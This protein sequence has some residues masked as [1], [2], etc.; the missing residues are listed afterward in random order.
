M[1]LRDTL[2]RLANAPRLIREHNDRLTL[3]GPA[4]PWA[5]WP[6]HL[7]HIDAPEWAQGHYTLTRHHALKVP[8]VARARGLICGT[9]ARLPMQVCNAPGV[10]LAPQ[11]TWLDRSD[12]TLP[13]WKR[14]ALAVEDMLFDGWALLS[15]E[16]GADGWPTRLGYIPFS[17]WEF[18]PNG[19]I[20]IDRSVERS[21]E[22]EP[23]WRY[24]ND[25]EVAL[26]PGPHEGVLHFG[27]DAIR[28]ASDLAATAARS[29][30]MPIPAM[31]LHD[32]GERPL[33]DEKIKNLVESWER[34][35][36]K[37][38]GVAYT[39][40]SIKLN[41]HGERNADL[42]IEGR[43]AAAVDIARVMGVPASLID[44]SSG[45]GASR[46]YENMSGRNAEF[47]DYGL[48]PFMSALVARLG[49][50]DL[51]PRGQHIEIDL[52]G[53]TSLRPANLATPDDGADPAPLPVQNRKEATA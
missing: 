5:T 25:G 50:D 35:L 30:R 34:V 9:I 45:D 49:M 36:Q 6:N 42:V 29:A 51:C 48:A 22:T 12:G 52:D 43:N 44:A 24:A 14:T 31:E 41:V 23:D 47:V 7:E 1:A 19:R 26:I 37:N 33:S 11:P 38:S 2:E 3:T 27:A 13:A 10:P 40:K 28:A 18:D 4:S 46:T 21:P 16:R 53:F 20:R 17:R 32:E 15:V 39:N 8:A